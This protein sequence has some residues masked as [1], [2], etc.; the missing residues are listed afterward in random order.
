MWK[1]E[2][3]FL[4]VYFAILYIIAF[5]SRRGYREDDDFLW[6]SKT[7]WSAIGVLWVPAMIGCLRQ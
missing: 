3:I 1:I 5:L 6:V 2:V 7:Q 4:S